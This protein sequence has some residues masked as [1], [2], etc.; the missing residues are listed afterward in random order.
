MIDGGL[1][2]IFGSHLRHFD[3]QSIESGMTGLGIPDSNYFVDGIE[4]WIEYKLSTSNKV[5]LRPEQVGWLTQR[6]RFGGRVFIAVRSRHAWGPRKGGAVDELFLLFGR[7]AK[8]VLIRGLA[9]PPLARW[10]GGQA[11]WDWPDIERR[12]R[13][14]S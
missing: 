10:T 8:E 12:L 11:R 5:K 6:S 14:R 9:F 4:G 7:D 3:W 1:R 2:P 13:G